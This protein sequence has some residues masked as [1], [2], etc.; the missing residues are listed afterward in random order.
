MADTEGVSARDARSKD[1]DASEAERRFGRLL[2]RALPL[3]TLGGAVVTF[4]VF[5]AGPALLVMV[6]GVLLST[7]ALFWASLRTLS[8]DAPL[9]R[10][11]EAMAARAGTS[12]PA[13]EEKRRVLRALKD[14]EHEHAIGKIDDADYAEVAERYRNDA[15]VLMREMDG[16]LDPLRERAEE[17]ARAH[18]KKRRI[19]V[20][21]EPVLAAADTAN[22]S[23][24]SGP[25]VATVGGRVAC[26]G[27]ETSNE[28]DAAF[29]KKCGTSLLRAAE[30]KVDDATA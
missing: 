4:F 6:G 22:D 13:A 1:E 27:C 25:E 24:A 29:C 17:I 16:Q 3:G 11:L 10:D 7:I 14:L 21:A 5:S 9:P 18:L 15:K 26:P 8:G 19:G 30:E 20:A 12:G 2:S 28:P 23:D